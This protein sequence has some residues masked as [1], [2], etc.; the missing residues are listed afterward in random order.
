MLTFVRFPSTRGVP[1]VDRPQRLERT[2]R[3]VRCT[4]KG[5]TEGGATCN[6]GDPRCHR[7]LLAGWSGCRG[8]GRHRMPRLRPRARG[9][10]RL[11]AGRAALGRDACTPASGDLVVRG[12]RVVVGDVAGERC[13]IGEGAG[14]DDLR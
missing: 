1:H 3:E 14:L 7:C 4:G 5:V 8:S 9:G 12:Q 6:L 13:A 11:G 2:H 10:E